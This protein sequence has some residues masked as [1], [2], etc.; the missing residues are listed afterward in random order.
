MC[1]KV[2]RGSAA[3]RK[4][5]SITKPDGV[6]EARLVALAGSPKPDVTPTT[7]SIRSVAY[8]KISFSTTFY[9]HPEFSAALL[10][11]FSD[12]VEARTLLPA[13]I[14]FLPGGLEGIERG[15]EDL[16]HG[17]AA[18]GYKLVSRLHGTVE[19]V[20][21]VEKRSRPVHERIEGGRSTKRV[22]V[23]V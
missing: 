2:L 1:D 7:D 17:R 14:K 3:W 23:A 19:K 22:R 16:R 21:D 12:L 18:G 13:R 10:D 5:H 9:D 11:R 15:L 6:Q 4:R 20:A 8:P